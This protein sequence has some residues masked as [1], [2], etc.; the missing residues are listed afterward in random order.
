MEI[1]VAVIVLAVGVLGLAG[2]TTYIV[3][4]VTLANMMTARSLALQTVIE[5]LQAMPF[6]S[7][8]TGSDSI[9]PFDVTWSATSQSSVSKV[10]TI[11]TSGPG[12][13]T[14]P[15]SA[16]ASMGSAVADTFDYQVIKP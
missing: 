6:D 7:V 4:Q 8:V 12:L 13:A 9:G 11:I 16:F 15:S 10:V 14:S 5:E 2:T 3:R 1:V